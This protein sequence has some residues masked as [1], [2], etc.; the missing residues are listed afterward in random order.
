VRARPVHK[1]PG[2]ACAR[3]SSS[4]STIVLYMHACGSNDVHCRARTHCARAHIP[5][6]RRCRRRVRSA[7]RVTAPAPAPAASCPRRSAC[8]GSPSQR[9]ASARRW[10][11]TSAPLLPLL[12]LL[13]ESAQSVPPP[14]LL[15]ESA[16]RPP[17][18]CPRP[19]S[20]TIYLRCG[21]KGWRECT[22]RRCCVRARSAYS[23]TCHYILPL[24]LAALA[25][26]SVCHYARAH[27]QVLGVDVA[28]VEEERARRYAQAR[29][30]K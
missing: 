8:W 19:P 16:Q 3:F 29:K 5:H 12:L 4:H 18:L 7:A 9:S 14:L 20:S 24:T 22:A 30:R 28:I 21:H 25:H 26:V 23:D 17:F 2:A 13:A 1:S 15:T 11:Y 27:G 6:R 10:R